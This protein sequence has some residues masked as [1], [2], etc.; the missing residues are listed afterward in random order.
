MMM[1]SLSERR[2][3]R[4]GAGNEPELAVTKTNK[5]ATMKDRLNNSR[6]QN[7][8]RE[9]TFELRS[10]NCTGEARRSSDLGRDAKAD[11]LVFVIDAPQP[12]YSV[13]PSCA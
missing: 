10:A 6:I 1:T 13:V 11:S 5:R 9:S 8:A 4:G 3:L 12:T 2:H 7:C